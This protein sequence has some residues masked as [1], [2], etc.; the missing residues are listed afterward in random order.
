MAAPEEATPAWVAAPEAATE[1]FQ[2]CSVNLTCEDAVQVNA[3]SLCY[4]QI[5]LPEDRKAACDT[6]ILRANQVSGQI[7]VIEVDELEARGARLAVAP[8]P[9]PAGA[10]LGAELVP[11]QPLRAGHEFGVVGAGGN[12]LLCA[13]TLSRGR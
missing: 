3:P 13:E 9:D 4:Q 2:S 11:E 7:A 10:V 1:V 12:R 6:I 5:P 8:L